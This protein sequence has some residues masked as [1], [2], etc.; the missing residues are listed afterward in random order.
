MSLWR[1]RYSQY[2]SRKIEIPF[3][4]SATKHWNLPLKGV[5]ENVEIRVPET[6]PGRN[7]I[8]PGRVTNCRR[9]RQRFQECETRFHR[10]SLFSPPESPRRSQ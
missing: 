2:V 7:Y 8:N 6:R 9:N 5:S 3:T 1:E 10:R 4:L